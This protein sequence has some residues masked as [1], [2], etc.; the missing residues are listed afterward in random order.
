MVLGQ[1]YQIN[2]YDIALALP[3]NLT[4]YIPL[5]SISDKFTK[6]VEALAQN[7]PS[8]EMEEAENLDLKSLFYIGQYLRAYVVSTMDESSSGRMGKRHI[9]LS[10]DPRKAN[11]GLG[12]AEIVV[13]SMIQASV[14]SVEDHG[15]IMNLGLEDMDVRGFMS[16]K[17]LGYNLSLS[18]IKDGAVFLCLVTGLSSNG[19]IIKLSA[20]ALKAGNIKKTHFLTDA[21]S[22][23]SFLPGTA[24]EV[25]VS[26]VTGS[27]LSGKVMGLLDVTA[28]LF[29]SGATKSEKGLEKRYKPGL[30]IKARVI[31]SFLN[32]DEKKL[33]VSLL[34]HVVFLTSKTCP[35]ISEK[36]V[37][38]A[39]LPIST[40]IEEVRVIKVVNGVG[41]FVDV[42]MKGVSG[43]VHISRIADQKIETLSETLGPYKLDSVHKA[44]V[45]GYNPMDGLFMVSLEPKVI[46]QQFLRFEDVQVGQAVLGMVEKL[47]VDEAGVTG[48]LVNIADGISGLVPKIHFAD[49]TLQHPERKFQLGSAVKA[50]VLSTH[51]EKRQLRLT[52]KKTLVNSDEDAWDSYE[53]LSPGLQA[54]GTLVNILSTGAVVQFF[55]AVRGFLPISE[56]SE[57]YIENPNDHFRLGQVVSVRIV[58]LDAKERRMIVSC[59]DASVFSAAQGEALKQLEP[60]SVVEGTVSEKTKDEIIVE[61]FGSGL[62]AFLP[63]AHLNDRSIHECLSL[64][65]RIRVNQVLKELIVLSKND[66]KRLIRLTSKPSLVKAAKDGKLLKTFD[67]VIEGA[68]IS[69][70]VNNTTLVGCFIEFAAGLTGLLLKAHMPD[71]VVK[72]PDFGMARNQSITCRVLRVDYGQRRFLLTLNPIQDQGTSSKSKGNKFSWM[73]PTISNAVDGTITSSHDFTFGRLT[74][75]RINSIKET[76]LNVQLADGIQGRIDVSEVFDTWEEIKDPK[77]PLKS[78]FP[79]HILNVRILGTYDSRSHRFLP[80]THRDKAPVFELTA[81]ASSQESL[82]LEVLTL[83]KVEVGST[84]LVFVNNVSEN[85][86]WVNLSPNVRG[87]ISAMDISDDVSL[88]A[89]LAKNFP[90]GSALRARVTSVD[91]VNNRL[92]LSAR[93]DNTNP[94]RTDE[95]SKGMVLPGRVTKVTERQIMVQLSEQ[96]SGPVSLVDLA[97]DY[98]QADP[99]KYEKNQIIRVC[100]KDVDHATGK[101]ILSA[102][103]SKVLSSS[104][105]VEDPEIASLSQLN[106]ND[107]LRGFVKNVADSG[108]FVSIASTITAFIRVSDL[109]DL[110]LKDWKSLF[111]ID[112]LVEGKVI[113]LD[114]NLNHVQMS[115]KKSHVDLDYQAPLTF[116]DMEVGQVVTGKVRKVADFGVF[117]VVDG[118]TNVSGLCHR[119]E[120][121]DQRAP[122]PRKL[123]TEGDAV[124]AKILKIDQKKKQ[125]SFGLKA[126]YFNPLGSLEDGVYEGEDGNENLN[127]T[128]DQDNKAPP[129]AEDRNLRPDILEQ[130]SSEDEIDDNTDNGVSVNFSPNHPTAA[131]ELPALEAGGF[132]WTGGIATLGDDESELEIE[133]DL[134]QPKKKRR[135]KAEI[136]VDKTGDLDANGPQSTADFERLLMG[137]PNSSVLWLTYMAFQLQLSEV[138]RAREIAERAIRT[139]NIREEAEKLNVW[140]AMLNLENTYGSEESLEEVFKRACQYNDSEEI[141]ERLISIYIQSDK[142]DVNKISYS[143]PNRITTKTSPLYRKPIPSSISPSRNSPKPHPSGSTTQPSSS[144]PSA[145]R[146]EPALCSHAPCNPS[147]PTRTFHS[148]RNLPNS[149]STPRTGPPN[150][151]AP[152]SRAY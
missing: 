21:P 13:N 2:R 60:G 113:A 130:S 28:D 119:S 101:I 148:P 86:I 11:A 93:I 107:I 140:V 122:D 27:G 1:V 132:D 114:P 47:I 110:Y 42:G 37:P 59:K 98:S 121:A 137:Q 64:A 91:I 125:I 41:L 71:E 46:S 26:E 134:S 32:T 63:I 95:I 29:H 145:T 142:N 117:I 44:R 45:T 6:I 17:E 62:K 97:D 120:L 146:T 43:F 75:A 25:L 52:L 10:I 33:G 106:V 20:D 127:A 88:L 53:K 58:S 82:E 89:D 5:T 84:R 68:E 128:V 67:E 135:R 55:G 149:N 151:D 112:Q 141:H 14:S 34:D 74:K 80:I 16:S 94:S 22:V 36:L 108:L 115:L 77:H 87:R 96:L 15:V 66:S 7:E 4:G 99:T 133:P 100:V 56:M 73:G 90:V 50:R 39:V 35:A 81:K 116:A 12:K 136:T 23:D 72:T 76:Q 143:Y 102:R 152:S 118:S 109:S 65:K 79:K 69:G 85:C 78:F 103:P 126:S 147:P 61:L 40:V 83:E 105:P 54:P 9:E 131:G 138:D 124:Q 38:T 31:C 70:F 18:N 30:K 104:L 123:Y 150:E 57:S 48:I 3:N 24:V 49:I 92:D 139:I 144:P 8:D 51:P 129:V 111:E 19:N